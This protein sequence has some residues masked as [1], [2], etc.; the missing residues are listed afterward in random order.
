MLSMRSITPL[1]GPGRGF[2]MQAK[3]IR[4]VLGMPLTAR[5]CGAADNPKDA[6]CVSYTFCI[7][8][9]HC[10]HASHRPTAHIVYA[11]E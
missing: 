4:S 11:R 2:T 9:G 7:P 5:T 1:A 6:V 10:N 3:Y 8:N